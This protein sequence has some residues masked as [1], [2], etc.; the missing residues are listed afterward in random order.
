MPPFLIFLLIVCSTA[1]AEEAYNTPLPP[2]MD[3]GFYANANGQ[4][5]MPCPKGSYCDAGV[6]VS[7]KCPPGQYQDIERQVACRACPADYACPANGT[8]VPT[9]CPQGTVTPAGSTSCRAA[10]DW[11][12]YFRNGTVCQK[13]KIICD[14]SKQYEVRNAN[15]RTRERDCRALKVC[16]TTKR[17]PIAPVDN[18][19]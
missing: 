18:P 6:N 7:I 16:D 13:R 14:Y 12:N 4:N 5:C 19:T 9:Q 11:E 8:V 10:C 2:C 17:T 3:A 15:N 1:L